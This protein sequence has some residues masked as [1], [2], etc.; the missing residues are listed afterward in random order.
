MSGGGIPIL[1]ADLRQPVEDPHKLDAAL[2]CLG[3]AICGHGATVVALGCFEVLIPLLGGSLDTDDDALR[4][5]YTCD[6][7]ASLASEEESIRLAAVA[8]GAVPSVVSVL[9]HSEGLT[10][11][12][13]AGCNALQALFRGVVEWDTG[14]TSRAVEPICDFVERH[15][16]D[17]AVGIVHDERVRSY[18]DGLRAL[19]ALATNEDHARTIASRTRAISSLSTCAMIVTI[20]DWIDKEA[21]LD[22]LELL[23]PYASAGDLAEIDDAVEEQFFLARAYR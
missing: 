19:R 22:I 4:I 7:I 13:A 6:G 23:R 12:F 1:L 11:V 18:S 3:S 5:T 14:L 8:A 20:F 16:D 9:T 15:G 10:A 17:F 21:L 2:G